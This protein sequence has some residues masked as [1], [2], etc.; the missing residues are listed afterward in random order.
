MEFLVSHNPVSRERCRA[1]AL[2]WLDEGETVEQVTESL[3]VS[4]RMVCYWRERFH[5]RDECDLK[6]RLADVPRPGRPC[7][8][9]GGV[10]L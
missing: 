10:D 4:R 3:R 7:T 5:N 6:Q 9:D 8:V 2:L 1:Q